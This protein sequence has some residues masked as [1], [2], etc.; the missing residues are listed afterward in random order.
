MTGAPKITAQM[1]LCLRLPTLAASR[2][3]RTL[4][5]TR[6]TRESLEI[7]LVRLD[8]IGDCVLTLPLLDALRQRYPTSRITVLVSAAARTLFE[9]NPS[10]DEVLVMSCVD[11]SSL[12]RFART[13]LEALRTYWRSLRGREFDIAISP[14]WDADVYLATFLC[15]MTR[16][17]T[18][19]GFEDGT[20]LY[21]GRLNRGFDKTWTVRVKAGP[22][23]HEVLHGLALAK[24]VGCHPSQAAQPLLP[25]LRVSATEAAW[26]EAWLAANDGIP[27][28]VGLPAAEAKRRW[29][30]DGYLKSLRHLDEHVKILPVLLADDETAPDAQRIA[31]AFPD[32]RTAHR[33]PLTQTAAILSQCALFI[34]SDSGLGHIAAAVGCPTITLSPHPADGD[35]A[36]PNSPLRFRPY[37][38]AAR[39]LQP[40]S[41]FPGC[42]PACIS[43]EQHCILK[44]TPEQ[45]AAAAADLLSLEPHTDEAEFAAVPLTSH[46]P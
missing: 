1:Q 9:G 36:H 22:L 4:R 43:L 46:A 23:Q 25:A 45:V 34:G 21:K 38:V 26:A 28:A 7:L 27:V 3:C 14:R 35:P 37:G 11:N 31:E 29:T 13:L 19:V 32:T 39:V 42:D 30:A 15:A 12:P 20:S 44:I 8:G 41:G 24:A 40:P 18:T 33:V 16:A 6:R 17:A 10:V 2:L 5:R